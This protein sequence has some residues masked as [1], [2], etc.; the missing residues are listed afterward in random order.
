VQQQRLDCGERKPAGGQRGGLPVAGLPL[1]DGKAAE[2]RRE[3][4]GGRPDHGR[5]DV[6]R[7]KAAAGHARHPG[8]E[9]HDGPQHRHETRHRHAQ[10]AV[11]GEEAL[12]PRQQ[13]GA[14]GER[15]DRT[16]THL[17]VCTEPERDAVA[18]HGAGHG[19][20]HD[21]QHRHAGQGRGAGHRHQDRRARHDH[22]K[23]RHGF[24]N[25]TDERD[26]DGQ[27]RVGGGERDG[28]SDHALCVR[29]NGSR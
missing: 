7:Q 17:V 11:A 26:Q 29:A 6:S 1:P 22:A 21:W 24:H 8:N 28:G 12:G 19:R 5:S 20:Q 13:P 14:T 2:F 15:P 23:H 3:H 27:H 16:D 9:R 25:G 10:N 4:M 18:E